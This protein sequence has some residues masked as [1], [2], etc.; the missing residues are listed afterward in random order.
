MP[1][2]L[3]S[4]EIRREHPAESA[5]SRYTA[6]MVLQAA[7][8]RHVISLVI[9][10]LSLQD[11]PGH[12][13]GGTPRHCCCNAEQSHTIRN[14]GSFIGT[15]QKPLRVPVFFC[16]KTDFGLIL[17]RSPR[18]THLSYSHFRVSAGL[19]TFAPIK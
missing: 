2:M 4:E 8:V 6:S 11:I 16:I 5:A 17:K 9:G 13:R 3:P 12:G 1:E 15:V 10:A 19:Q 18:S 14:P 7:V